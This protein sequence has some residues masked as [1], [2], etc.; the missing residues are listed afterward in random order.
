M[1]LKGIFTRAGNTGETQSAYWMKRG[2]LVLRSSK[3]RLLQLESLLLPFCDYCPSVLVAP[4]QEEQEWGNT[5]L[6]TN[7]LKSG[8]GVSL[9]LVDEVQLMDIGLG[10]LQLHCMSYRVFLRNI[11]KAEVWCTFRTIRI[12]LIKYWHFCGC[13]F[14]GEKFMDIGM[15]LDCALALLN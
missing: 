8:T 4:V 11:V 9:F 3:S 6:T 5:S 13:F 1:W 12:F 10:T 2:I 14:V 15:A 7:R